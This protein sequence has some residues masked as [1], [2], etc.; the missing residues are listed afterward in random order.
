[1]FISP[2]TP[3]ETCL[4]LDFPA[5]L[6]HCFLSELKAFVFVILSGRLLKAFLKPL[7]IIPP[8]TRFLLHDPGTVSAFSG[9]VLFPVSSAALPLLLNL[10]PLLDCVCFQA[11]AGFS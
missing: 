1:L 7:S 2:F 4:F 9:L 3:H 8:V 6:F 5:L 11:F 10:N